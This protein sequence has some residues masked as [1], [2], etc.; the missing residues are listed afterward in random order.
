MAAVQPAPEQ[1]SFSA[2]DLDSPRTAPRR[3]AIPSASPVESADPFAGLDDEAERLARFEP[4]FDVGPESARAE[5][6]DQ[7]SAPRR[8]SVAAV[9]AVEPPR[10]EDEPVAIAEDF[11]EEEPLPGEQAAADAPS[12][13]GDLEKEMARLLGEISGSRK[14]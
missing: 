3:G 10:P 14:S 5:D 4:I 6:D 11:I 13:V 7:F 8:A 2:S 1:A 12:P 9:P